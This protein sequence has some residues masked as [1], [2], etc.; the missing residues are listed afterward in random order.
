MKRRLIVTV[1]PREPGEVVIPVERGGRPEVL[2][3]ATILE[4]LRT[5]IARRGLE[6]RVRVQQACAGGCAGDGPNVS[7]AILTM[8]A[9]GAPPDNVAIAWRTYVASLPTLDCLARVLD[10]NLGDDDA[11]VRRR[12]AAARRATRPAR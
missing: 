9:P 5:L 8:P 4:R 11:P 3:A 7:V 2:N 10:D 6:A 1:C 12:R